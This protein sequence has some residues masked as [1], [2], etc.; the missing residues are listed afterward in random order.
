MN[1]KAIPILNG[2][3]SHD[4]ESVSCVF[5]LVAHIVTS[6]F[7]VLS[8]RVDIIFSIIMETNTIKT[9]PIGAVVH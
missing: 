4:A 7:F 6:P 9:R 1:N 2:L 8:C 3:A 5:S